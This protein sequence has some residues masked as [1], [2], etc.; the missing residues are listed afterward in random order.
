MD[1]CAD[2]EMARVNHQVPET[3]GQH[4]DWVGGNDKQS[5]RGSGKEGGVSG[6]SAVG[7]DGA[8]TSWH[9]CDE[10]D[11]HLA[12]EQ[13][14][15]AAARL[16]RLADKLQANQEPVLPVSQYPGKPHLLPCRCLQ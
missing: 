13:A 15:H 5:E 14:P 16:R 8:T 6:T 10:S 4:L 2:F 3:V 7:D 11:R 1:R 9:L 12:G